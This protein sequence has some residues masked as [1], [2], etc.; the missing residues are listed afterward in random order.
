MLLLA[1]GLGQQFPISLSP[2]SLSRFD[3]MKGE[4]KRERGRRQSFEN[5]R[6]VRVSGKE[7]RMKEEINVVY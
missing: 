1:I 4:Q 6:S 2:L 3:D 5:G 7:R